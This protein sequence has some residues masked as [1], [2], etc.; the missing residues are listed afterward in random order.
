MKRIKFQK[1]LLELVHGEP[2]R[3]IGTSKLENSL[4]S[5]CE[6]QICVCAKLD[7][8]QQM[9][10]DVVPFEREGGESKGGSRGYREREWP[11]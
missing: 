7:C 11:I 10:Y 2:D 9:V 6:R 8:A 1:L 4:S 5:T 3:D